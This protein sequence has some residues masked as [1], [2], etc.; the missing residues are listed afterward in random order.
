MQQFRFLELTS[1]RTLF[2]YYMDSTSRI[3]WEGKGWGDERWYT[4]WLTSCAGRH[5][6]VHICSYSRTGAS[7]LWLQC[8]TRRKT[9]GYSMTLEESGNQTYIMATATLLGKKR[10]QQK[11][12]EKE[13]AAAIAHQL[14][15]SSNK[16][17]H[18]WGNLVSNR[19]HQ[20]GRRR[21]RHHH[22]I[23][24]TDRKERLNKGGL[25]ERRKERSTESREGGRVAESTKRKH[26]LQG[27][28]TYLSSACK[29]YLLLLS[30][31]GFW[32]WWGSLL[33]RLIGLVGGRESFAV[34]WER[35]G[36]LWRVS[37]VQGVGGAWSFLCAPGLF[38]RVRKLLC[39]MI[40]WILQQVN[41]HQGGFFFWFLAR[42]FC[43]FIGMAC[44]ITVDDAP[45]CSPSERS[46]G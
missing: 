39:L 31:S 32:L 16:A 1:Q 24:C 37:L 10:K 27:G 14:Q 46:P 21:R 23:F 29:G 20:H 18:R 30:R 11:K 2:A 9:C 42:A 15:K 36:W 13:Q 41:A 44:W 33:G 8:Y 22:H 40:P 28:L 38:R 35:E 17:H 4:N 12:K 5:C 34:V 45:G 26:V 25:T 6:N 19:T 43:R 3:N 7:K